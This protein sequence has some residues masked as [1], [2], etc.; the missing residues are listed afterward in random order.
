MH[1]DRKQAETP[2][3]E[4]LLISDDRKAPLW[5]RRKD[6]KILPGTGSH[7]LCRRGL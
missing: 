3:S 7:V 2:L 4:V 5:R 6:V 1:V